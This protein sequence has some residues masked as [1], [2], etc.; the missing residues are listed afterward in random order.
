VEEDIRNESITAF[1][2][3]F[4]AE[5]LVRLTKDDSAALAKGAGEAVPELPID[6]GIAEAVL[7]LEEH[8]HVAFED[9]QGSLD[10]QCLN[11]MLFRSWLFGILTFLEIRSRDL[12][13]H[14]PD[15]REVI[16]HGR[17]EKAR[18]IKDERARRG[19]MIET[20]D[21]LQFGDLG[22][23]AVKYDGWYEYFGVESKKQAKRLVKQLESLRNALAHSQD[24]VAHDWETV[25]AV[26]RSVVAIKQ[27]ESAA[28]TGE[29][30]A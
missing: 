19:R 1:D 26:A 12:I 15:W 8:N 29:G 18:E 3:A 9:R 4:R 25:V 2:S 13:R 16:S 17:L 6:A 5:H 21:A 11:A 23:L 14:D 28:A 30:L 10:R 7:A 22:W 24:I 20:V 27:A